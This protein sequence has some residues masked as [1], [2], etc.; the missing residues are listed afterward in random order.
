MIVV[1]AAWMKRKYTRR[2][3]RVESKRFRY[4]L[5]QLICRKSLI[6]CINM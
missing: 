1:M 4:E 2:I 5:S 6:E 3:Q